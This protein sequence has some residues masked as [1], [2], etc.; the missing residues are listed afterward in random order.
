MA[1]VVSE[2]RTIADALADC[3]SDEDTRVA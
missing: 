1:R 3:E 2:S